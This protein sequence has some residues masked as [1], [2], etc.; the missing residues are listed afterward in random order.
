MTTWIRSR[1]QCNYTHKN[2]HADTHISNK[3]TGP[4]WT[5]I[6][7]RCRRECRIRTPP[8]PTVIGLGAASGGRGRPS[9]TLRLTP[10]VRKPW[11]ADHSNRMRD[12]GFWTLC[13]SYK[14]TLMGENAEP[15]VPPQI[16]WTDSEF[17]NSIHFWDGSS[18][19]GNQTFAL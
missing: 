6:V 18:V 8:Q 19:R 14:Y 17:D 12:K 3:H 15:R 11:D 5:L 16:K 1:L 4:L 9:P 13:C 7:G 10:F 2:T